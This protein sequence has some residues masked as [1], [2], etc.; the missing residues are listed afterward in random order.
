[1]SSSERLSRIIRRASAL[2]GA[3]IALAVLVSPAVAIAPGI[4]GSLV[5]PAEE[6]QSS[7]VIVGDKVVWRDEDSDV[8]VRM[9][10]LAT[11]AMTTLRTALAGNNLYGPAFDGAHVAWLYDAGADPDGDGL[12]DVELWVYDVASKTSEKIGTPLSAR[13]VDVSGGHVAAAGADGVSVF[14]I[15]HPHAAVVSVSGTARGVALTTDWVVWGEV[16][17]QWASAMSLRAERL[18]TPFSRTL[19]LSSGWVEGFDVDGSTLVYSFDGD[20]LRMDVGTGA[21]SSVCTAE[22]YQ[23]NPTICGSL[24][25]W[26][27]GRANPEESFGAKSVYGRY[28][29]DGGEWL[30]SDVW[31]RSLRTDGVSLTWLQ[32][33]SGTYDEQVWCGALAQ[34]S[35]EAT[36]S[37]SGPSTPAYAATVN[38]TGRLTGAASA[39]L[40]NRTVYLRVALGNEFQ[41]TTWTTAG[42]AKTAADGTFSISHKPVC[43]TRYRVDFVPASAD[44]YGPATSATVTVSP[45]PD[46][47]IGWTVTSSASSTPK[48]VARY[49]PP[50]VYTRIGDGRSWY[51]RDRPVIELWRKES[52]SWVLRGQTLMQ[53]SGNGTGAWAKHSLWFYAAVSPASILKAGSYRV[54][55]R[56]GGPYTAAW[57]P[58]GIN[59]YWFARGYSS[60]AYMTVK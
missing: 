27:D 48:K 46:V 4:Q 25:V 10:D 52:G 5:W 50:K 34:R 54:R 42:S 19:D 1:M 24:V 51:Y 26:E 17:D 9:L 53:W 6:S 37:L 21:G 45:K 13:D 22:G 30:L 58:D 56:H 12:D 15:A 28:L 14:D 60:W 38:L 7:P 57:G 36:V 2:L 18:S 8:R 29:P 20:I 39:P 59:D 35:T 16:A 32:K 44:T 33:V 49:H 47:H 11:G 40:P 31:A 3:A 55:V 43:I 41:S 23:V